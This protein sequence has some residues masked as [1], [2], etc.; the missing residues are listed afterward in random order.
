MRLILY[1]NILTYLRQTVRSLHI[2][3][4][5]YLFHAD[6]AH[7]SQ[8]YVVTCHIYSRNIYTAFSLLRTTCNPQRKHS[9][10]ISIVLRY[11]L[12]PSMTR[13]A[14]LLPYRIPGGQDEA[15]T[16]V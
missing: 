7:L 15:D 16:D 9:D 6:M 10:E 13:S 4:S 2:S 8:R 1:I 5:K 11:F 14:W 3:T 12:L